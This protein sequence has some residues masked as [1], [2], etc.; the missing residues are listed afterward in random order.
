MQRLRYAHKFLL[1]SL[2]IAVPLGLLTAL[3]LAE[4]DRRLDNARQE[5]RGVEY[6]TALRGLL[7]P[8]AE[9][10]A[11]AAISGRREEGDA[12]TER[13]RRRPSASTPWIGTSARSSA[14]RVCGPRCG[15]ASRT[16]PSV[17]AC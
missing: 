5:M 4:L 8:L 11:R 15:R 10:D 3:W 14:R 9:A 16:A 7:E 2:L 12:L 17:P 1:L 6:L 13:L